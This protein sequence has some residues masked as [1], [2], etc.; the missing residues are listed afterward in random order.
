MRPGDIVARG[1]QRRGGGRGWETRRIEKD[2]EWNGNEQRKKEDRWEEKNSTGK[3]VEA[4]LRK[5][6]TMLWKKGGSVSSAVKKQ[7]ET[8]VGEK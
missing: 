5:A 1:E 8:D 7:R 2:G 4:I 6:V 3:R